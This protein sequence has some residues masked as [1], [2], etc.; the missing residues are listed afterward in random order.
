[1]AKN[2]DFH[3]DFRR[4]E[5]VKGSSNRGFGIVFAVFFAILTFSPLT[6]GGEIR[7]VY[8]GIPAVAFLAAAYLA[9]KLLTPLNWLWTRF[10]LL[11]HHVMNPLIMG[12]LFFLTVTPVGLVMRLMGKDPL[13][14]K[15]DRSAKTYWI[16][17]DPPGPAP[18]T[19]RR[20][21]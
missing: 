7:W 6:H 19:M 13:R 16:P 12:L 14:L 8:C 18:D 10:G 2:L 21:F 4:K 17:R 20:Q 5:E 3:E 11:L 1:M 15:I 9:P